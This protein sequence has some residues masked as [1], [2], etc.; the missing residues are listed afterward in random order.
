[1]QRDGES[2]VFRGSTLVAACG[3]FES[4]IEWLKQ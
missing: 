1:V 3:G 4:N 2:K